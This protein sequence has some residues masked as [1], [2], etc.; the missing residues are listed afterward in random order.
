MKLPLPFPWPEGIRAHRL[1]KA[2]C[3]CGC[4]QLATVDQ[5]EAPIYCARVDKSRGKSV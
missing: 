2:T 5:T 3:S 1:L 4:Y